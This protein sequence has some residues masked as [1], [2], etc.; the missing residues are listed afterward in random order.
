MPETY[1]IPP[2]VAEQGIKAVHPYP[3][4]A[5]EDSHILGRFNSKYAYATFPKLELQ[6]PHAYASIILD[7]DSD[8]I[9]RL[10]APGKAWWGGTPAPVPSWLVVNTRPRT[11]TRRAGGIHCVFAL[12]S[13]RRTPQRGSHGTLELPGPCCGQVGAPPRGRPRVHRLD[14][15]E[16][17]QPRDSMPHALG[18][19]VSLRIAGAGQ[20]ATEG[21]AAKAPVDGDRAQL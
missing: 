9:K 21:Q 14:H 2:E 4:C 16:S 15:P 13:T 10:E 11:P 1:Y 6:P 5:G 8:S 7:Y 19:D 20:A 3:F 12:E 17:Y 18:P